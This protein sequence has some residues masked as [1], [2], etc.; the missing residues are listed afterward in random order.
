MEEDRRGPDGSLIA[1]E[2]RESEGAPAV[3]GRGP[4]VR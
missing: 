3:P 1:P 4:F 2:R